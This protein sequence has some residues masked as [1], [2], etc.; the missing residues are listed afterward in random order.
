[1]A[2]FKG[3][4]LLLVGLKGDQGEPGE[5]GKTPYIGEN[6]NWWIG[7]T[8]TGVSAAGEASN[9]RID[10]LEKKVSDLLYDQNPFAINSFTI[11]N[12]TTV[13]TGATSNGA[14]EIGAT[15]TAVTLGWKF[16]RTPK[17]VTLDGEEQSV[18]STGVSLTGLSITSNKTWSLKA[19]DEREKVVSKT[20]SVSFVNGVYYGVAEKPASIDS[21]FIISLKRELRGSKLKSFSVNVTDNKY[22]WYCLPVRYGDCTFYLSE[23]TGIVGS[24]GAVGLVDTIQ[25]TNKSGY[26]ESYNVYRSDYTGLEF[27]A[28]TVV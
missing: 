8:D 22:L 13:E 7:E 9:A 20:A 3:K 11:N 16:N 14:V 17:S 4:Q 25:F 19:T 26:E 6:G 28:V 12:I 5:P 23:Q 15:V 27:K 24:P 2:Y 1:M 21:E 18:D 10:E